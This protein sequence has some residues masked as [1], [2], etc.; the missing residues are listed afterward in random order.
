MNKKVLSFLILTFL[1]LG[2]IATLHA[3][4]EPA[5]AMWESFY[6]TP[7]NTKLK[8][9]GEAMSKHNKKYHKEGPHSAVVYNV[10][11]GPNIGKIVW[12]MGPLNFK[13]LDGRPSAGGHDED[14]RDNVMPNVKKLSSGEYWKQ[15]DD[16]SNTAMLQGTVGSYPILHIRFW[17][18]ADGHG[19]QIDHL[20]DQISKTVKDMDGENPWGLYDNQFRQGNIG[21]HLATVMFHKN[22]ADY[23][24]EPKFKASF[25]KLHGEDSWDPFVKGMTTAFSNSWDEIWEYNANMSGQ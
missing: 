5:Y 21:R 25:L 19:Y 22:W 16:V 20:M 17:E 8:A 1:V 15:D 10:V 12:Q 2:P 7:D 4:D 3:Q 9:L 24:K 11:S 23:D 13:H 18:V 14:W 6:I